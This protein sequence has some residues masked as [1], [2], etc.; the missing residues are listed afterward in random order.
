MKPL[1]AA[2]SMPSSSAWHPTRGGIAT[3]HRTTCLGCNPWGST[4][5]AE[6][7]R[8]AGRTSGPASLRTPGD[9]E[10]GYSVLVMFNI[11]ATVRRTGKRL[12][13]GQ[14]A[15]LW[16]FDRSG[17]IASFK[18]AVD[19]SGASQAP[20]WAERLQ[21]VSPLGGGSH[22]SP[23]SWRSTAPCWNGPLVQWS[24]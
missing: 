8:R 11:D 22:G 17:R 16:H 9:L 18:N 15:H 3:G 4:R 21:L 14:G 24:A 19:S 20:V 2:M 1:V 5:G 10:S 6:I 7:L 23:R 12:D 13:E